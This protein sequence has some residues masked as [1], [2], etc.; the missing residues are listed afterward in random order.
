MDPK[1]LLFMGF[2]AL[3]TLPGSASGEKKSYGVIEG[4]VY[5]GNYDGD[6]VRFNIPGIHPI[7]GQNISVR[8]RGIDTPEIRGKCLAEIRM[9]KQAKEMLGQLLYKARKITL[10]KVVRGKYFRIVAYV[11]ADGVDVSHALSKTGLA[12]PYNGGKKSGD[13]CRGLGG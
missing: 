4:V 12:V 7:F 5:L 8:L 3:L 11:V 9:A 2:F 10:K 13:W 1:F 6:T